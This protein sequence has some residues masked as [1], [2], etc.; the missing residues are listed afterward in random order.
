MISISWLTAIKHHSGSARLFASLTHTPY[1]RS[2]KGELANRC[3]EVTDRKGG[4]GGRSKTEREKKMDDRT[5]R[6]IIFSEIEWK[7]VSTESLNIESFSRSRFYLCVVSSWAIY[8]FIFTVYTISTYVSAFYAYTTVHTRA[9]F[10]PYGISSLLHNSAR[11]SLDNALKTT[12][13]VPMAIITERRQ[14]NCGVMTII[15]RPQCGSCWVNPLNARLPWRHET[16]VLAKWRHD[17]RLHH[18]LS[19]EV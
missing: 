19:T 14:G 18:K 10:S 9:K 3:A 8:L 4:E 13:Y 6:V 17:V 5:E 7:V 11:N 12:P 1:D 2:S 16:A 15:F